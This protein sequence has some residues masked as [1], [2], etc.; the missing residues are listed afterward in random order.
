MLYTRLSHRSGGTQEQ[1]HQQMHDVIVWL[2]IQLEQL[3]NTVCHAAGCRS[4]LFDYTAVVSYA[5]VCGL[6]S[7]DRVSLKKRVVDS[8]EIRSVIGHVPALESCLNAMYDC[9]YKEFFRVG[10]WPR[11]SFVSRRSW[12]G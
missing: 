7:L 5:V 10:A 11:V 8:P 9:N 2:S 1:R 12:P 3:L 6:V 4:E